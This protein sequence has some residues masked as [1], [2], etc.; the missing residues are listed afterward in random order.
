MGKHQEDAKMTFTGTDYTYLTNIEPNKIESI[1]VKKVH[2]HWPSAIIETFD[3]EKDHLVLFFAKNA[4]MNQFHDENGYSLNMEGEGC[5]MLCARNFSAFQSDA[6]IFNVSTPESMQNV[7]RYY[8]K[9]LF[10]SAWEYTLVLPD[11]I[12]ESVF[13]NKIHMFLMDSILKK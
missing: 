11:L 1:F 9:L 13:A 7:D 5:F 12:E 6:D 3:R 2:G 10:S 4:E 8:S